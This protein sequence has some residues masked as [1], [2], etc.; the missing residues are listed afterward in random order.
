MQA[1]EP[2]RGRDATRRRIAHAPSAELSTYK[3]ASVSPSP[4]GRVSTRGRGR[5]R[6][7]VATGSDRAAAS[8]SPAPPAKSPAK[9]LPAKSP[10]KAYPIAP[11]PRAKSTATVSRDTLAHRLETGLTDE[12]YKDPE[13]PRRS[14]R[15]KHPQGE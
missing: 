13:T 3:A 5:G 10:A 15:R 9:T 2:T 8:L 11:S 6:M 1:P 4:R 12:I 14:V 7:I